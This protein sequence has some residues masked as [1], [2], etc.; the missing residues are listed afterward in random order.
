MTMEYTREIYWNVGHNAETLVPMYLF[1]FAAIGILVRG[2]LRRV[3]IYKQGLPLNRTD[4]LG[5]RI[6]H[7]IKNVLLQKKVVRVRWPGLLHGFFFWGFVLLFIGTTLIFIQADFTDL[8][9]DVKF[10]KG[11]FYLFF[12]SSSMWRVWLAYSC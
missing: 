1:A 7:M 6:V 4:Q 8:F 12:P 11:I 10:L 2:F 3:E 9:F 5:K